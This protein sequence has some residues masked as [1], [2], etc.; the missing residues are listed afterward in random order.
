MP[1]MREQGFGHI[2]QISSIAGRIGPPGRGAYAA[3]KWGVERFS[4]VLAKQLAPLGVG[5]TIVE[6]GGFR[7]DFAG[8]STTIRE[9]R[10]RVRFD[11]SAPWRASNADYPMALSPAIRPRLR[12]PSSKSAGLDAPPL[13]LLLGSNA[14]RAA[15]QNETARDRSRPE[16]ARPKP[17]HRLRETQ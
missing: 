12:A 14:V 15:E 5:V 8:R 2:I 11:R 16:V 4:E 3:A 7:T 17:L 10:F 13:R 1:Y 6:P 9:G